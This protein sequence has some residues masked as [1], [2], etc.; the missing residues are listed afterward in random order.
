VREKKINK[1]T[2]LEKTSDSAFPTHFDTNLLSPSAG[3]KEN[4]KKQSFYSFS[5]SLD[6]F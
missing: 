6:T 4:K 5:L 3:R 2:Q 1:K